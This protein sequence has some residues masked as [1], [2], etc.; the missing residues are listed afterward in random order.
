MKII[1]VSGNYDLK[2]FAQCGADLSRRFGEGFAKNLHSELDLWNSRKN[3]FFGQGGDALAFI[4]V[5]GTEVVG[6]IAVI[7]H[8]HVTKTMN[9]AGLLGLYACVDD[10]RV[11]NAL[12]TTACDRLRNL[13]CNTVIG[14]VDFSIWH[15]YRFMTSG[16]GSYTLMGEPRNPAHYPAQWEMFGFTSGAHWTTYLYD[17]PALEPFPLG[18]QKHYDLG[19]KLGYSTIPMSQFPDNLLMQE[20]YR[21][22]MTSYRTFPMY[23]P[24]TEQEFMSHYRLMPKL[25]QKNTSFLLQNPSGQTVGFGGQYHDFNPAITA[26]KGSGS[27]AAKIRFLLK[28]R[29]GRV[30]IIAQGGTL[31]EFTKEALELGK[32]QAGEP[33]SL[34]QVGL[35][36]LLHNALADDHCDRVAIALVRDQALHR[37]HFPQNTIETREYTLYQRNI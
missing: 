12:L 13:R 26:M 7:R 25:I 19:R 36:R 34:G 23:V 9:K 1:E 2:R 16:F 33:L 5:N 10:E 3:V 22:L 6:R 31:T 17:R 11:S 37:K 32:Q 29:A 20:V 14:P 27:L 21:L 4:A 35:A 28:R 8:P 24:L 30:S 18:L 15:D